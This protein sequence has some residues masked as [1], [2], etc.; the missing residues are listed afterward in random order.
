METL[1]SPKTGAEPGLSVIPTIPLC[2]T[3]SQIPVEE[4]NALVA[5]YNGTNGSGWTDTSGWLVDETPCTWSG[6]TCDG[7]HVVNL[8]LSGKG[9]TGIIPIELGNLTKLMTLWLGGN[10]IT[11]IPSEIVNLSSLTNLYLV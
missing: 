3:Q 10:Q 11:E 2:G 7:E 9:L 6:V 8:N 5:L 4:C 1:A